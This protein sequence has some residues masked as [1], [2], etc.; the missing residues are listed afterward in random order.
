MRSIKDESDEM[1]MFIAAAQL[2]LVTDRRLG[3]V[4][5]D[6]VKHLAEEKSMPEWVDGFAAHLAHVEQDS[7]PEIKAERD[8]SPSTRRVQVAAAKLRLTLD[9]RLGRVTPEAVK[10]LAA[11]GY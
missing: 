4:T 5:P 10:K 11:E 9:A 6:W 1:D 3:K 2:R 8:V 7:E